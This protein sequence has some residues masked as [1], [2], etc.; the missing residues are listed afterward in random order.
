VAALGTLA[1]AASAAFLIQFFHNFD[2]TVIDLAFHLAAVGLVVLVGTALRRPLL[3][4]A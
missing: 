2:V 4:A 1:A 3:N